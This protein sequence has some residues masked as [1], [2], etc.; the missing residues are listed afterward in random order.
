M[1]QARCGGRRD[2]TGD[3]RPQG[4]LLLGGEPRQLRVDARALPGHQTEHLQDAV[5]HDAGEPVPLL[6]RRLQCHRLSEL[7]LRLAAEGGDEAHQASAEQQ[8]H[9]VVQQGSG[10]LAHAPR[11]SRH[12]GL[13]CGIAAHHPY[14]NAHAMTG[15]ATQMTGR[16]CAPLATA[17]A[18]CRYPVLRTAST[19]TARSTVSRGQRRRAGS[20]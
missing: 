19:A 9:D 12:P 20:R 13:T 18:L 17:A 7:R 8:Q 4:G 14:T 5:V 2:T 16:V 11:G 15:A 10:D 6:G 1:L 3:Q